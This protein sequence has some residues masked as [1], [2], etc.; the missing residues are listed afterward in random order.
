MSQSTSLSSFK[1]VWRLDV[2]GA[3][4]LAAVALPILPLLA[5]VWIALAPAPAQAPIWGH[6]WASVLPG[7]IV[8]TALLMAGVATVTGVIG[9][10]SAWA[11]TFYRFPLRRTLSWALLLPLAIPTYLMAY[12][13]AE[14]LD[15]AGPL[16]QIWHS[17]LP[18]TAYPDFRSL[19]G[20]IILLS[21]VLYPYVYLSA[22]AAFVQQSAVLI[23]AGRAL[24]LGPLQCF[25]R[26][27]LPMARP[28]IIVGVAL[29]MMECLNDIGAVEF[30][31]VTTLTMGVY[32]T[33][34]VRG[35]L[36]GAA[37]IALTLLGFM[38]LLLVLE[39]SQRGH[40]EHHIRNGRH[41]SLPDFQTSR[42]AR[43]ALCLACLLPVTL[44]F[45]IPTGLLIDYALIGAT[46]DGVLASAGR[47]FSL[48]MLAAGL[49]C[50]LGLGLTYAAR[51]GLTPKQRREIQRLGQIA[52]LGYAVPGTVLAIGVMLVFARL[53]DASLGWITLGGTSVALVFAYVV[54]FLSLSYGT[55]EAGFGRISPG[56]DMAARGLGATKSALL[57]RVHLPLLR[58]PLLTAAILVFVDVM[59]ELPATLILRPFDFETLATHVYT[60]ASVGQMEDAALP[61]LMIILVGLIPVAISLS[62][63][64][65]IRKGRRKAA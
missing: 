35:N 43:L 14:V 20:A 63:L 3:L 34:V 38:A 13:Y 57:W 50:L 64:E 31:G 65:Q 4:T 6:L 23:E 24:G 54:R 25:T 36:A 12:S 58:A 41:R 8:T 52:A 18:E 49:T 5:L 28:A 61:A 11:V 42:A 19:P 44:G 62:L 39:R 21:L 40:A 2:W 30:L 16:Y 33:W 59:K 15:H 45:I 56:L 29:A 60:Y 17:L 7:Q 1:P 22:R 47:S 26:I 37:Q 51:S 53:A 48:A 27:G 55:L 32:D 9:T 46:A 10:G